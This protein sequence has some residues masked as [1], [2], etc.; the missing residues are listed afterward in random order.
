MLQSDMI[1][2]ISYV[3]HIMA[4]LDRYILFTVSHVIK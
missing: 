4:Y 2:D 1:K 3:A